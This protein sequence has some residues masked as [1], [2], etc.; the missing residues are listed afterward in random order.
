M[1]IWKLTDRVRLEGA[2]DD[3]EGVLYDTQTASFCQCN[4]T[5]WILLN[6][7]G[8]GATVADLSQTLFQTFNVSEDQ[9]MKDVVS[10]LGQLRRLQLVSVDLWPEQE[11][12]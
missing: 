6:A 3:S 9:A 2:E 5:A 12:T 8:D 11:K 10:L 4:D 7:L 1:E